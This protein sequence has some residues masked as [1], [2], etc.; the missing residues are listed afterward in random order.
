MQ[1]HLTA[2]PA[3]AVPGPSA[4]PAFHIDCDRCA[5]RGAGCS[6]CVVSVL[7]GPPAPSD[8]DAGQ[9]AVLD[10]LADG[11]LVPPLRLVIAE[12][13]ASDDDGWEI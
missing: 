2:G 7:L 4:D 6:D 12:R 5:A 1:P 8:L 10:T 9:R 11:G 3:D 13:S